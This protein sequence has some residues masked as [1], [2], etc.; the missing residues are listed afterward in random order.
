M[1]DPRPDTE[2]LV[3]AALAL[4][5]T[6]CHVLDLGAGSGAIAITLLAER[7]QAR[8]VAVDVSPA[9]LGV[10]RLNAQALGVAD[11]LTLLEG[12]WFD[13]VEGRFDLIVSNPP[14]VEEKEFRGLPP[15]VRNFDPAL[16]LLGGDDGLACYRAI[17]DGAAGHISPGGQVL[18]EI[19]AGQETG[20]TAVFRARRWSRTIR[21]QDLGGHVR[22]LGFV[23]TA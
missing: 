14:Y 2:T 13:P 20:V 12:S 10:A 6:G 15:D 1:L 11:R 16:A 17:A 9:A 7:P 8:A 21:R 23:T 18:V 4:M 19:G 22:C 3:D 5:P